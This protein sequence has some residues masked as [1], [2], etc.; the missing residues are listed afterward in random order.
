MYGVR[1]YGI[2][3]YNYWLAVQGLDERRLGKQ[4]E[5]ELQEGGE[6]EKVQANWKYSPYRGYT[7]YT[8]RN[9]E[10]GNY[11]CVQAQVNLPDTRS[12]LREDHKI[13]FIRL[14]ICY[15]FAEGIFILPRHL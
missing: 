12:F 2:G 1:V 5:S 13:H 15:T 11:I 6:M 8:Y 14:F 4:V 10:I 7:I 9:I 3:V